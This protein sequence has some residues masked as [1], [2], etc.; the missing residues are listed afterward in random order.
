MACVP[1]HVADVV[2]KCLAYAIEPNVRCIC[3]HHWHMP[4]IYGHM[5]Y[6]L[7]TPCYT[8]LHKCGICLHLRMPRICQRHLG[9]ISVACVTLHVAYARHMPH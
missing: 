7:F 5:W 4:G 9:G 3:T 1:L 8:L 6:R 2:D